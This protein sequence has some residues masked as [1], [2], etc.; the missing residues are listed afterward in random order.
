ML[1]KLALEAV[2]VG[3]LFFYTS[4]VLGFGWFLA[5]RYEASAIRLERSVYSM[6]EFN[7]HFPPPKPGWEECTSTP[8][9]G[10][11]DFVIKLCREG[12]PIKQ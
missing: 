2:S 7:K 1:R 10:E 8:V 11:K 12:T 5:I 6:I 4:F 9:P 3:I